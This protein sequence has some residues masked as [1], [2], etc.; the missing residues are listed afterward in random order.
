VTVRAAPGNQI[1][2][3]SGVTLPSEVETL[4]ADPTIYLEADRLALDRIRAW[5]GINVERHLW[6]V[7][8]SNT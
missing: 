2:E 5:S 3:T 7:R 4:L 1:R 6:L 8:E